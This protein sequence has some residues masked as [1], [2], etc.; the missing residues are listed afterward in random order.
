MKLEDI[1]YDV[2]A[3]KG[4]EGVGDLPVVEGVHMLG[5][6]LRSYLFL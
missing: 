1:L 6:V 5:N 2:D 4:Y 3:F